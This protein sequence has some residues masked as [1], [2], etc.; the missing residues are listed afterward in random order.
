M[1]RL[2]LKQVKKIVYKHYKHKCVYIHTTND[3]GKHNYF[4]RL[5]KRYANIVKT[6][7]FVSDFAIIDLR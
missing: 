3:N 1:S 2:R 5:L 4:F 7:A 6:N